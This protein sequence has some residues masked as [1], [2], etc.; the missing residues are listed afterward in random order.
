MVEGN[1]GLYDGVDAAGEY[2]TAELAL[3][4]GLPVLLVVNCSK[5][6]RTVA[7][8]V[9]GCQA[10]DPRV[11]IAGVILNQIATSRQEAVIR[12]AV[13]ELHR[14]PG[15]RRHAP[16]EAGYLPHAPSGDHP[17]PGGG[18]GR[19][20]RQ[21][22]GS[23]RR[24]FDLEAIIVC[25]A[26]GHA[27]AAGDRRQT[28][29]S[30]SP[31]ACCGTR[32]SVLLRGEPGGPSRGRRRPGDDRRPQRRRP[33]RE[34]DG[35]YI[36]GGFP[37]TSARELADNSS[38]RESV[39]NAAEHGLPIYAECGGLIFL[40]RSIILGEDEYPLA[41]VF[42]VTFGMGKAPGPRLFHFHR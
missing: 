21:S 17:A 31:S 32:L 22:G 7:A 27:F 25:S 12:E 24:H 30:R 36:G 34:L 19:G 39:R 9:L 13:R 20:H 38:F 26:G 33:A 2:S 15:G 1:R 23:W 11:R 18:V 37:E 3:Q 14:Y 4:L 10:F 35:L 8:M 41:G 16:A 29:A 5:T 28:V 40:G 42:P 6:T